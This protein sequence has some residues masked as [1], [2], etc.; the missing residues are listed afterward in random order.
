M[1]ITLLITPT[2]GPV[3]EAWL[4]LEILDI[5][6]PMSKSWRNLSGIYLST[7]AVCGLMLDQRI[8]R[9]AAAVMKL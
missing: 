7:S 6:D 1:S 9:S 8:R 4:K 3:A 2:D 5:I